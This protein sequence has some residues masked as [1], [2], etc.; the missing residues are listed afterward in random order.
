MVGAEPASSFT[1]TLVI[2]GNSYCPGDS[3]DRRERRRPAPA[4][5]S[6][7]SPLCGCRTVPSARHPGHGVSHF[8]GRC[9]YGCRCS[10]KRELKSDLGSRL[11]TWW[12]GRGTHRYVSS[13]LLGQYE[14]TPTVK[15]VG[16][17]LAIAQRAVRLHRGEIGEGRHSPVLRW[18]SVCTPVSYGHRT[19]RRGIFCLTHSSQAAS[20]FKE[21]VDRVVVRQAIMPITLPRSTAAKRGSGRIPRNR[22]YR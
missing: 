7:R 6:V 20:G 5:S 8:C 14:M 18:R 1:V 16:L 10:H 22:M 13:V 4:A 9:R 3:G 12:T 19:T 11:W 2:P 21:P 15:G 17:G